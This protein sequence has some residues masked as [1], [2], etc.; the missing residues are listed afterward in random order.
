MS[1]EIRHPTL[2]WS[3]KKAIGGCSWTETDWS[4]EPPR[5]RFQPVE[6]WEAVVSKL[7]METTRFIPSYRVLKC[8]QYEKDRGVRDVWVYKPKSGKPRPVY[9]KS[10]D[11][12][13]IKLWPSVSDAS[14][15]LNIHASTMSQAARGKR[16]SAGGFRWEYRGG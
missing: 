14:R 8:P 11:G 3:C 13:I 10:M 4:Q 16:R 2:C 9:Q 5:T 1:G 15:E 6:G 7:Q 12:E